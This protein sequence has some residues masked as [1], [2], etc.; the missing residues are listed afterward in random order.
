VNTDAPFAR[1]FAA[2]DG[3][4]GAAAAMVLL[5]HLT[6]GQF[7]Q[8]YYM[9]VDLFFVMSGFVLALSYEN[10]LLSGMSPIGFFRLRI[11]RLWPLM[12][13]GVAIGALVEWPALEPA[14]L[15]MLVVRGLL[16]IPQVGDPGD[17]GL[18]LFVLNFPAWSLF[19][20]LLVN[21]AYACMARMLGSRAL[22]LLIL[23][24]LGCLLLEVARHGSFEFGA[25]AANNLSGLV[26]AIFPFFLG[27]G[28][29]RL[30]RFDLL[31]RIAVSPWLAIGAFG[32][33]CMVPTSGAATV[34]LETAISLLLIPAMVVAGI[35]ANPEGRTRAACEWLGRVSYPIY[36]LQS[37]FVIGF[38]RM[39]PGGMDAWSLGEA[40]VMMM[41]FASVI[42]VAWI[43]E[44]HL[45]APLQRWIKERRPPAG[46]SGLTPCP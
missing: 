16:L 43:A 40:I 23:A 44:A 11:L 10:R 17:P 28:L 12:A 18:K 33:A 37:G 24:S 9:A 25:W 38:R 3:Y 13:V 8:H 14:R 29:A 27:V 21:L 7:A 41:T 20:E 2:L 36:I 22:M 32:A 34:L 39:I 4:R 26:R 30:W 6:T 1:R 31:P 15:G 46:A 19:C 35:S 42:I 5:G 45:D